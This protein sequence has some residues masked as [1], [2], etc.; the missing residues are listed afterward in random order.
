MILTCQSD[1]EQCLHNLKQSDP[2]LCRVVEIAGTPQL[3]K[4]RASFAGLANIINSQQ[5]STAA[6][7]AIW[8]RLNASV[9]PLNAAGL[10]GATDAQLRAAG[11]SRPKIRTLRAIATAI[12]TRQLRIGALRHMPVE[13][14]HSAL[15]Q[16][17]GIGPWTADIYLMFCI[18]HQDIFPS[19]DIALQNAVKHAF[20]L[21]AR[22]QVKEL[23]AIAACWSP[24]RSVA[25]SVFW[26]YYRAMGR[27][28]GL[29][30][31]KQ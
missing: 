3:R 10:N 30:I 23:D 15:T 22:P 19:R 4:G 1:L 2:R 9:K 12:E 14:A 5:I 13:E 27:G 16:I 17:K 29:S 20:A 24:W 21:K 11:V 31:A 7:D 26:N 6:A 8:K 28:K 25:A 18:G